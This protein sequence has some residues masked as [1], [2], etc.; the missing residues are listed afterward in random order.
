MTEEDNTRLWDGFTNRAFEAQYRDRPY[1]YFGSVMY[2]ARTVSLDDLPGL[3]D[4][5]DAG[6][7]TAEQWKTLSRMDALITGAP[8]KERTRQVV[9]ALE[10]SITVDEHDVQRAAAGAKIL[11]DAGLDAIGAVAG[12]SIREALRVVAEQAGVA[13]LIGGDVADWPKS[14]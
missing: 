5:Y 4:A 14:A 11:R 3:A 6:R 2:K 12:E 9:V 1:A 8:R 13:V 7:I 10:A